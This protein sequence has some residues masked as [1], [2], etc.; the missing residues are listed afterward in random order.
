MFKVNH[1]TMES[2][3]MKEFTSNHG[4]DVIGTLNGWDR[5]I[6]RG[7]HRL[8]LTAAGVTWYLHQLQVRLVDFK[9][10]TQSVT[11][12]ILEASKA[13]AA[14]FDRPDSYLPS[15]ATSKEGLAREMLTESPVEQGLICVLRCVEPCMTYRMAAGGWSG[16]ARTALGVAQVHVPLPLLP[17]P[18]V[19]LHARAYSDVDALYDPGLH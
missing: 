17:R 14:F 8:L 11:S 18:R 7:L 12:G 10:F 16:K 3:T 6:F 2:I 4:A 13:H 1:F 5:L 15:S 19:W 9:S